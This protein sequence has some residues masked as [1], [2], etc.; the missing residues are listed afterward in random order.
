M[1]KLTKTTA[2]KF[3]SYNPETGVL[4]FKERPGDNRF[5][6]RFANKPA[7]T[8]DVNRFRVYIK[9][10]LR[11]TSNVVW[12]MNNG[13]I[14]KGK[15]IDHIN[16]NTMDDRIENLRLV[17]SSQNACNRKTVSKTGFKGV[18]KLK[19]KYMSRITKNGSTK[20]LGLFDTRQQAALAY[21]KAAKKL[22][23][24]YARI[25]F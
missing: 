18:T 19:G 1:N 6:A 21:D 20:Y 25:N 23:G 4:T 13:A 16:G 11:Y 3:L 14:P 22:H 12:I 2:N 7:G 9:N 8:L 17:T 24:E 5:N 15:Y 10:K